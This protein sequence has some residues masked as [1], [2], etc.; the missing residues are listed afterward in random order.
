MIL[1]PPQLL[2]QSQAVPRFFFQKESNM[3]ILKYF[4]INV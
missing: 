3:I 1:S 4:N 2:G